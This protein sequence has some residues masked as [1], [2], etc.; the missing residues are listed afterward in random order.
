MPDLQAGLSR[1]HANLTSRVKKGRMTEQ[2]A[3]AALARVQVR[4]P[5]SHASCTLHEL[6]NRQQCV[7]CSFLLSLLPAVDYLLTS[8][9]LCQC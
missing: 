7:F 5:C 6:V 3:M 1:I 2:A 4:L 8:P 9:Q